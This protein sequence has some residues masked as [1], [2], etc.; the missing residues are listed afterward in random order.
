MGKNIFDKIDEWRNLNRSV[1]EIYLKIIE[2]EQLNNLGKEYENLRQLLPYSVNLEKRL[3]NEIG[4]NKNNHRYV[5]NELQISRNEMDLIVS[6]LHYN[7]NLLRATS[8]YQQARIFDHH[9]FIEERASFS[10]WDIKDSEEDKE[11]L[12][13]L[14]YEKDYTNQLIINYIQ[15]INKYISEVDDEFAK[16]YLTYLK[17]MT[18][19]TTP[20]YETAYLDFRMNDLPTVDLV[21]TFPNTSGYDQQTIDNLARN[22]LKNDIVNELSFLLEMNNFIYPYNKR[23]VY[24]TLALNKAR[25]ISLKDKSF[26]D[27]VG[28]EISDLLK[29]DEYFSI[30]NKL[31]G[32]MFFDAYEIIKKDYYA[33]K[34]VG[35]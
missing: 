22:K 15:M 18:I 24:R 34:K 32:D 28:K 25:L 12:Q 1:V 7:L 16:N 23:T 6:G 26:I 8:L 10:I 3:F 11:K 30:I 4:I 19:S 5:E 33:L 9:C 20:Q 29:Q 2:Y 21:K 17:Y 35:K 27:V 31:I 13:K 14:I